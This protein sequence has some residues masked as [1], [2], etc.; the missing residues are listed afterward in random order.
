MDHLGN[1]RTIV[2]KSME[3]NLDLEEN[4]FQFNIPEGME[5]LK[6]E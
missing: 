1:Y 2:L 6:A 5:V 3:Y 4:L